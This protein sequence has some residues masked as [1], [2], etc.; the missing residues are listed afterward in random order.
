MG[1]RSRANDN[2]RREKGLAMRRLIDALFYDGADAT[3]R[4]A[5]LQKFAVFTVGLDTVRVDIAGCVA[6]VARD[7]L[8]R[9][10]VDPYDA[11]G[12]LYYLANNGYFSGEIH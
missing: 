3:V 9:D 11:R 12:V 4:V 2:A 7:F 8:E 10:G 6:V 5:D 1:A